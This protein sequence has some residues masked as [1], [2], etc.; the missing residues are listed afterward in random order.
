M[1]GEAGDPILRNLHRL[2]QLEPDRARAE[3]VRMRCRAAVARRDVANAPRR[4]TFTSRVIEPALVGGL[5]L[6]YLTAVIL[7]VLRLLPRI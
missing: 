2:P 6:I 4:G 5:C 7:D 1:S 3:R